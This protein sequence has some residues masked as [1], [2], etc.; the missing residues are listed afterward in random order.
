[1][2]RSFAVLYF[3]VAAVTATS[4]RAA[5]LV[6][7]DSNV[8]TLPIGSVTP[9][10][11]AVALTA[12]QSVTLIASDGGTMVVTG[13]YSGPIGA[14]AEDAPGALSRLAKSRE[15]STHVVGAIRAP[16]WDQ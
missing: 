12:G 8:D 3:L 2:L 7:I 1:M 6:V 13:P 10:M 5:D 4:L 11:A 9:D 15:Q 16:S 14:G